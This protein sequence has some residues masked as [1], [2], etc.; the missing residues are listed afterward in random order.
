[1][2]QLQLRLMCRIDAP[3]AVPPTAV[4]RCKSYRDAV[5]ACW[6]MRSIKNMSRSQLAER[7][8]LYAPH[9]TNY[10]MDGKHQRDLPG[11]AV[12]AFEAACDNTCITQWLALQAKFTV[13]EEMQADAHAKRAVA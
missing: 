12:P 1:M 7:A 2:E 4:S 3:R 11:W 10:L 5:K 6:E 9:V 13:M 8:G